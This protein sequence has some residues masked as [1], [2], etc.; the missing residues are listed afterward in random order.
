[1]CVPWKVR[2]ACGVVWCVRKRGLGAHGLHARANVEGQRGEVDRG[3]GV[4][5]VVGG[6][7]GGVGEGPGACHTYEQPSSVDEDIFNKCYVNLTGESG[8]SG[9]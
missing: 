9:G 8:E 3:M 2:A 6:G 4:R 7:G 1:M 5:P